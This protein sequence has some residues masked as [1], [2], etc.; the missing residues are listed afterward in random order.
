MDAQ[1]K[2][3]ESYSLFRKLRNAGKVRA[4]YDVEQNYYVTTN[5]SL[6]AIHLAYLN[7]TDTERG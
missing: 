4:A 3:K 5:V 6:D 2:F 7:D 1:S